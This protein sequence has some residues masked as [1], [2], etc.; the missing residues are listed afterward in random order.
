MRILIVGA[1]ATG[2]YYGGRLHQAGRDVSFLVRPARA[3]TLREHGLQIVSPHGDATLHPPLLTASE[4][5]V[6]FDIVLLSVKAY[7][8]PQAIA[9]FA[10]AVGPDTMIVPVLNGMRHL[11]L[12]TSRF[13]QTPVLG[14]VSQIATTVDEQG[15]IVQLND[16]QKLAYGERRRAGAGESARVAVLHALMDGAA[17]DARVSQ[18]IEREMWEKWIFLATLGGITCLMRGS[19]GD[20][21]AAPGGLDLIRQLLVECTS[22]AS[23]AGF[24]PSE[25]AREHAARALTAPGSPMVSSMYRDL[26]R[27]H[28]VEADHILGDLFVRAGALGVRTPVLAS[29][30]AHLSVYRKRLNAARDK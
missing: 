3:A 22:V 10:P 28:D 24:E 12:L 26:V 14:A 27:C 17:F 29:A 9:D 25:A 13:G 23:A 6:P 16:L 5:D 8:L 2:G 7:A 15:R 19:I 21:V 11:D 18:E 20:I 30:Y 1:G 4:I